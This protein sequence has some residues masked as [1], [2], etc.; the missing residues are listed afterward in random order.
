MTVTALLVRNDLVHL[1][2]TITAAGDM[3]QIVPKAVV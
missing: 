2:S 1:G 3:P